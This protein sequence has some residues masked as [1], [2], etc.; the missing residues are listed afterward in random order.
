MKKNNKISY[1][2]I[3]VFCSISASAVEEPNIAIHSPQDNYLTNISV[4]TITGEADAGAALSLN[5]KSVPNN[6][7][8]FSGNVTLVE[9]LNQITVEAQKNG[10]ISKAVVNITLDTVS[11]DLSIT[12]PDKTYINSTSL[13][14]SY[15]SNASDIETY[16][17]RL[18]NSVWEITDKN[19]FLFNLTQGAAFIEVQAVDRAGNIGNAS[20]NLTVDLTPP[21]IEIIKPEVNETIST[22]YLEI[23]GRTETGANI[24]VNGMDIRNDN[25]TWNIAVVLS[26]VN[27]PFHI[28]SMDRA[29]NKAEK[30]IGIHLGENFRMVIPFEDFSNLS[31][32][33]SKP[34]KFEGNNDAVSGKYVSFLFERNESAFIG[35][36]IND[37]QS[38]TLWFN[39]I[40]IKN[41]TADNSSLLGSVAT[42]QQGEKFG[43]NH[44]IEVEIHDN[45][46]GTMLID[47]REFEDIFAKVREYLL[48]RTTMERLKINVSREKNVTL[49]SRETGTKTQ[50]YINES[51]KVWPEVTFELANNVNV[52]GIN[53]GFRFQK[54]G[55][56]A[57]LFRANYTGGSS[58]FT[59][60]GNKLVA[61]VNNSLLIFRQ[62]QSLNLTGEDFLDGIISQGISEGIIGAE[63][64]VDSVG[65]YDVVTFG[66]LAVS[67]GFPDIDTMELNVSSGSL[68]G[69]VLAV[70]MSGNFYNNLL[71]KNMTIGYDGVE[72][73]QANGYQDIMDVSNDLGHAEYMLAMGSNG[74]VIL[75]SIPGFSSHTLSFKFETPAG[76]F[77]SRIVD[78]FNFL[79]AGLFLAIPATNQELVFS[80]WWF[81]IVIMIYIV[82]R[83]AVRKR[84]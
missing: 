26:G 21:I 6:N 29:G 79:S 70:G 78:L 15:T 57:Y 23:A 82:V 64:Y 84:K 40:T 20:V 35:Y 12:L 73:Y 2:L 69:T 81:A 61:R 49:E 62:L 46:M 1:I 54:D 55:K 16:R 74:A 24:S 14:L 5:K 52:T 38:T 33:F 50:Y 31:I 45:R 80:G 67:A 22:R 9:G 63:F 18:N 7:G 71:N 76:T 48:N 72:I 32:N 68:N 42:Y 47:V 66:D 17:V 30:T 83:K 8:T 44:A 25:G 60:E 77:G 13:N 56:K 10:N 65:S 51:W 36:S 37:S 19:Y 27:N 11:P 39:K 3:L 43:K 58:D 75:V 28:E 4:I 53:N 34:G 59:V 41:F